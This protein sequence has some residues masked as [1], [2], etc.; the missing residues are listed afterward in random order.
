MDIHRTRFVPYP[1]SAINALAFSHSTRTR[2]S[3][4]E[5]PERDPTCLRL[6]IGRANGNIEIW[7][8]ARGAWIHET[9]LYGG[10]ERSVEGLA[11]IQEP[12]EVDESGNITPGQ[13]R[14]F[15]IGYTNTV[16][17][18]DLLTG[19]P[20]R[21]SGGNHGDVWCLAA[22]P[23]WEPR[24]R[25]KSEG[26]KEID[27][28][29]WR[30]QNLVVGCADGTLAVLSTAD[31]DLQFQKFLARPSQKKTR[32]L[33]VTYQ[34]RETVVAGYANGLVGIYDTKTGAQIRNISLGAGHKGSKDILVW[35]VKALP[36]N[37]DIVVG[38]STGEIRFYDGKNYSQLARVAA[39]DADVL[40]LA[41]GGHTR[42]AFSG[43][44]DRRSAAYTTGDKTTSRWTKISQS[45]YHDHDVKAM[46]LYEGKDMSVV[47][48]G[49]K[50][51]FLICKVLQVTHIQVWISHP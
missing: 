10:K 35:T 47:V 40:T 16:T 34:N 51:E 22:Q 23:P 17:E 13:L 50:I 15:S 8:P 7:N 31:N 6:A 38:D 29:S 46:A 14:L 18:W 11:W 37:G 3:K 48:S 36:R 20:L 2:N 42:I 28:G 12:E 21:H 27:E 9:T 39:H 5:I 43:S 1:P 45:R 32:V 26:P 19:L 33:S 49:G 41:V 30:G 25:R 24:K 4:G 44:M